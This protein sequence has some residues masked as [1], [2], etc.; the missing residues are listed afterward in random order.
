MKNI[1]VLVKEL[2]TA[3]NLAILEGIESFFKDKDDVRLTVST[4]CQPENGENDYDYQYWTAVDVLKSPSFD[5][6][7]V[8]TNSFLSTMKLDELNR[9]LSVFAG[10]PVFSVATQLELKN[11]Y[12]T[13]TICTQA[14]DEVVQHL[15][16]KHN[17][18][19]I[20]F[21]S[22]GLIDSPDS[23][24]R[25]EAY[26]AALENNGL[27]FDPSL[28]YKGDFTPGTARRV[29]R[30]SFKS[31]DDIPFDAILCAND[32]TAGGCQ[33]E[34]LN[35]GADIPDDISIIGFDDD[36]FA[37]INRP[38][39]SSINQSITGSGSYVADMAWRCLN[40]E[41]VNQVGIIQSHPVYRQ[42]CGC[43]TT[44]MDT[45][46]YVDE[47][48]NYH[49]MDDQVNGQTYRLLREKSEQVQAISSLVDIMNT[50][51]PFSE[52]LEKT[53]KG[54]MK[55]AGITDLMFCIFDEPLHCRKYGDFCLPDQMKYVLR[56][57]ADGNIRYNGLEKGLARFNPRAMLIPEEYDDMPAGKYFL[58]S[59]TMHE[60]HYGYL[61]CRSRTRDNT[62]TSINMKL[63]TNV[64]IQAVEFQHDIGQ[65][66]ELISRNKTLNL[67]SRT[68]E[69]TQILNRRGF[70]DSGQ[71]LINL[72]VSTGKEGVV[73]F[74]DLDNLKTI[75]DTYGHETGDLAIKT[76]AQ[77]LKTLFRDSD[78][79]GRLSGD[80]FGIVAPGMKTK[81][82]STLRE[83]LLILNDRL[84]R[85]AGLPFTLSISMGFMKFDLD[86]SDLQFLLAKADESLYIEKKQKHG[87]N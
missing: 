52:F 64:L 82:I 2:T 45:S 33:V 35:L 80:E 22:A 27:S 54:S 28:V 3:Y 60:Y 17:R 66:D 61:W 43:I 36:P 23:D 77:V 44:E 13:H 55:A 58:Q 6:V 74:C 48:G 57:D 30:E 24:D 32:F 85:E 59:V 40:G 83:R 49:S 84:S 56:A 86:N 42:S 19:R 38:T 18:R 16:V 5:A 76:E 11:S 71:Q 53:L 34:L 26:M 87:D 78:M 79:V 67:Q 73:F 63:L 50:R 62:V 14:Y 31:K 69:L 81:F 8:I 21:F 51:T 29:I 47:Y 7:I 4:V 37:T 72:S 39:L 9:Q 68:D 12:Y 65:K 25:F 46:A 70:F 10:K 20:A 1:A 75:N 41:T 15:V